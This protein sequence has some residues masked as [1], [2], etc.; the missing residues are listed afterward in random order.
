MTAL[1][2]R[3]NKPGYL[4]STHQGLGYLSE[5]GQLEE[6]KF[7]LPKDENV[8]FN[9][10]ACDAN[11]RFWF[12]SLNKKGEN[13]GKLYVYEEGKEVKEVQVPEFAIGNGPTWSN[14][15]KKMY[16]NN[17]SGAIGCMFHLFLLICADHYK[18]FTITTLRTAAS[19]TSGPS[20][21]T[22]NAL[23]LFSWV[24]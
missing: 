20:S 23:L 2:F 14:D 8:R 1:A 16:F 12:H 17:T 24:R 6:F 13:V 4:V 21:T 19:P 15:G 18:M 5:D 9:D 7:I 11:G 10:G 3:R 22:M